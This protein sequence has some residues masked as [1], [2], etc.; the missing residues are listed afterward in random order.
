MNLWQ[1]YKLNRKDLE[2]SNGISLHFEKGIEPEFRKLCIQFVNWLR[3]NY[4]FPV[5]LNVYIKDFE[6][7]RLIERLVTVQSSI[8]KKAHTAIKAFLITVNNCLLPEIG[9]CLVSTI[10]ILRRDFHVRVY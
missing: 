1:R 2:T 7:I 3:K 6:K 9:V 5:H 8:L 10:T 4:S